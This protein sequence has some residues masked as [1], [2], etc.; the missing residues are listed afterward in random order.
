MAQP[1]HQDD[2]SLAGDVQPVAEQ[3]T[4][5]DNRTYGPYTVSMDGRIVYQTSAGLPAERELL[6]LDRT[7]KRIGSVPTRPGIL[8]FALSSDERRVMLTRYSSRIGVV[9]LWLTEPER[10]TET[11]FTSNESINSR[12]VWSPDGSRVLFSSTRAGRTD[13]YQKLATG[14]TP[15]SVLLASEQAK[16]ATD[17]SAHGDVIVYESQG[18]VFA[19]SPGTKPMPILRGE[20]VE[21]Q[22]QLS[23]DGRWLAYVS[24]ESGHNDVYVQPFSLDTSTTAA[25][26]WV[27]STAGGTDPRWRR[28]GK[29]LFYLTADKL[30]A[31]TVRPS[32][33]GAFHNDAPQ[34]LFDLAPL[35]LPLRPGVFRYAVS[36][37]GNRF[38][39]ITDPSNPGPRPLTVVVNWQRAITR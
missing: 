26:R 10:G 7:G 6:W 12:P 30:M 1:V 18:D 31:A 16:T 28:D 38:L 39:V 8:D 33:D 2:L 23:P 9:D 17:W 34:P 37:D 22:A 13:I 27:V 32:T 3:V 5:P 11:R 20:F 36:H 25:G 14:T 29:E 24:N 19:F 4:S 15:E 21:T 35:A